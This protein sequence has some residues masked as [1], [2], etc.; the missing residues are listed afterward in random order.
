MPVSLPP[1]TSQESSQILTLNQTYQQTVHRLKIFFSPARQVKF[2]LSP[3]VA[4]NGR[5]RNPEL[6][7]PE[8]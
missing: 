4:I 7:N 6:S 3:D 5:I 8:N 2:Y 1:K